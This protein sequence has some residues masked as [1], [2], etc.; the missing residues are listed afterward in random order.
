MRFRNPEL[1]TC[2]FLTAL[3]FAVFR[4]LPGYEFI[5]LD[6]GLYVTENRHLSLGL[7]W[8][9]IK[10]AFTTWHAGYWIPL[11]WLSLLADWQIYGLNAGGYHLTN[12]LLHLANAILLFLLLTKTTKAMWQSAFVAALFAIHPLQVESVA[13]V[14]ERKDVLSTLFLML[15]LLA[16]ARYV[17][18]PGV[19]RY[20]WV[21]LLFV[22]GLM[23]K[24]MLVTLPFVLLLM[25]YWPLNR[26]ETAF[27]SQKKIM[28]RL[29]AEK[30]PLFALA[31]FFSAL[32]IATQK[33]GGA[34]ISMQAISPDIRAA[35]ALISYLRYIGKILWPCD[36]VIFYPYIISENFLLKGAAA[37]LLLAAVSLLVISARQKKYLFMGWFFFLGTLFP[38]I[39][40]SQSGL[41]AMADR[42]SY[43]P[44]IGLFIMIAWGVPEIAAKWRGK[45]IILGLAIIII[46]PSLSL[47][48]FMQARHWQN[49]T[50]LFTHALSV[51]ADNWFVHR[52]F[53]KFL[54]DHG[55]TKQAVFHYKKSLSRLPES[56][57]THHVLGN[58]MAALGQMNEALSHY[59]DAL[60]LDPGFAEAYN[61]MGIV[62]ARKNQLKKAKFHFKQAINF[63]PELTQASYNLALIFFAQGDF[64]NAIACYQ[65][66]LKINPDDTEALT[67]LEQA[68]HALAGH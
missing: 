37:G 61:S 34:V 14:T 31:A 67:R 5:Y 59:N 49:S 3:V 22:L 55:K 48:A 6:D 26:F 4:Q 20:L 40:I 66:I 28:G 7:S 38:V 63:D 17:K 30:I 57:P 35:N 18:K 51:T 60:A 24:P 62:L 65:H 11:T 58:A 68:L 42:F 29:V 27:S 16:Y 8:Q 2:L 13:W 36:L 10:W 52:V 43:I 21:F 47:C 1:L 19:D 41:Q 64:S 23:A 25:D 50:T 33:Y 9:G 46:I 44:I 45:K 53:G 54:F 15:I 12:L 39:G 56:A 32:T